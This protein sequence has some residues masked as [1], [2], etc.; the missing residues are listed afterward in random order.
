MS[1]L[2]FC[3][4]ARHVLDDETVLALQLIKH[5]HRTFGTLLRGEGSDTEVCLTRRA[6]VGGRP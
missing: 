1:T 4:R 6:K 5:W 2:F 3:V